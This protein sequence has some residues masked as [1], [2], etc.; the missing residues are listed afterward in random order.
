MFSEVKIKKLN[1]GKSTL[2]Y[3]Q[4]VHT[5]FKCKESW[6]TKEDMLKSIELVSIWLQSLEE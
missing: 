4:A 2:E 5:C 6:I 3:K 1:C